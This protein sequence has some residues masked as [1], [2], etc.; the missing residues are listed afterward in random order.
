M[1]QVLYENQGKGAD[2][3]TDVCTRTEGIPRVMLSAG[4]IVFKLFQRGND[5][6]FGE[7]PNDLDEIFVYFQDSTFY[8]ENNK[9]SE[10]VCM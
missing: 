9:D 7:V 1:V 6:G 8:L 5:E 4:S 10:T 2:V 3:L